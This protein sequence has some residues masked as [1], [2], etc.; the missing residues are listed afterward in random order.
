M[1]FVATSIPASLDAILLPAIKRFAPQIRF[2]V[3]RQNWHMTVVFLGDEPDEAALASKLPATLSLPFLP[4]ASISHVGRG[5]RSDQLW[6]YVQPTPVLQALHQAVAQLFLKQ[7]PG[8]FVP[9][10]KLANLNTDQGQLGE[11]DAAAVATVP[12]R[13]VILFA[14]R[15]GPNT[16]H[17]E[18]LATAVVGG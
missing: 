17:Y 12:I 3:P 10:I 5:Q 16:V 6:A 18:R 15:P 14:S 7:A 11:P 9:H 2:T 1:V 8:Q 4:T 13:E